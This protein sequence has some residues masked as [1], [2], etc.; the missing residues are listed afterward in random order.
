MSIAVHVS[1]ELGIQLDEL[2]EWI[3]CGAT[4][5]H[6]L[7]ARL[8]T[9]LPARNLALRGSKAISSCWLPVRCVRCNC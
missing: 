5:A 1:A 9:A 6:T 4:A 2:D 8:A 7:N 3:C